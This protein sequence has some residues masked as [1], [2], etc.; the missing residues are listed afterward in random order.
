[1]ELDHGFQ[2]EQV[3][4]NPAERPRRTTIERFDVGVVASYIVT[5]HS[6]GGCPSSWKTT[7]T[8]Q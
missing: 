2:A 3:A 7:P 4:R 1:L 5:L 6:Q 8:A